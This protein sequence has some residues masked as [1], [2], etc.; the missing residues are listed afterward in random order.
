MDIN[1]D[2][3]SKNPL[4]RNANS[5]RAEARSG[6][7][8]NIQIA[9]FY[10]EEIQRGNF[11]VGMKLPTCLEA[12]KIHGVAAQTVNQAF[13][14]LAKEGLLASRRGVGTVVISR[15][16]KTTP[17][18]QE[19]RPPRQSVIPICH[20]AR[21]AGTTP[22]ERELVADYIAGFTEGFDSWKCRFE[23]AHLRDDQSDLDMVRSLVE[24][25]Q[26]RGL[27][28]MDLA[29]DALDYLVENKFPFV[30]INRDETERGITSV[31]ADHVHGYCATWQHI[32]AL[33]HRS[34]AFFGHG[35]KHSQPRY[36]ELS[37]GRE[38][39]QPLCTLAPIE[40][41]ENISGESSDEEIWTTL[42][43]AFGPWHAGK[44]ERTWP[45]LFFAQTDLIAARLLKVLRNQ[46][47]IVP[48][49]ISVI[50]FND[51]SF[52][53]HLHPALTTLEKP[54]FKMALAAAR[55]LL[56]I[57][58]GRPA[59]QGILQ[60]FPVRLITRESC[61]GPGFTSLPFI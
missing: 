51:E 26:A 45:T 39:A 44:R 35:G 28:V 49:D 9:N 2:P 42:V 19:S 5:R 38:L 36:R 37:S 25:R 8:L 31:I 58:K 10:R 56:E 53:R 30:L 57:L 12:G 4:P 55:L 33:G 60:T 7:S 46:G 13:D 29:K 22:E 1:L 41:V 20:V 16:G 17:P 52:A 50:G 6:D 34:A 18:A 54:R 11:L 40:T 59:A 21:L 48:K 15:D 32:D 23:I 61:A 14:I 47:I 24:Y 3:S 27:V 43:R